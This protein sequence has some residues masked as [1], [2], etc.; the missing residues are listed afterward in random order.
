MNSTLL[1]KYETIDQSKVSE[2]DKKVLEQVKKLTNGFEETD[3]AK[4]KVAEKILDQI[5][6]L[7]PD[8]V[9]KPQVVAQKVAKAKKL[10]K[11]KNLR[12]LQLLKVRVTTLCLLLKKSKKQESLGKMLWNVLNK[13]LK[14]V[15]SKLFKNKKLN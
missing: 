10:P 9:K 13:F 11:Q 7:N 14:N 2:K 6:T 8:A 1:K 12:L 4:N 3:E 15:K 5:T